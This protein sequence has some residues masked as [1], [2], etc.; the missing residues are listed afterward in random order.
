MVVGKRTVIIASATAATLLLGAFL[1]RSHHGRV[2]WWRQTSTQSNP[3]AQQNGDILDA[4]AVRW[5]EFAYTQYV[6]NLDY[7]CNS[8]MLFQIL[9]RLESKAERLLMYPDTFHIG[10]GQPSKEV[11][12][13][14]KAQTDYDVKLKPVSVISMPGH[15]SMILDRQSVINRA[16]NPL[17]T[18]AE[19]F[20][21]LLAFNQTEYKR[22]LNLD[23]DSTVLQVST[24]FSR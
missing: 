8:V 12:L 9:H 1:W 19:S 20:T 2:A 6:T 15:D 11:E 5:S 22:V 17:G 16:D 13:L 24:L 18:W 14:L 10:D 3:Q 7:L 23:S 21:K 4:P